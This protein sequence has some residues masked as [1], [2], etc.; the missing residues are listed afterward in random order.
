MPFCPNPECPHRKRFG[1]PAEY[2]KETSTCS[3]CGSQLSETPPIF[4]SMQ[5]TMRSFL[6]TKTDKLIIV[7]LVLFIISLAV[8]STAR[9]LGMLSPASA[10]FSQF[11]LQT[12]LLGFLYFFFGMSVQLG[13]AVWLFSEVKKRGGRFLLWSFL[14]LFTGV[15]AVILWYLI[16][17]DAQLAQTDKGE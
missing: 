6:N 11:S 5:K 17:I 3:D 15:M 14:G 9:I 12:R 2:R 13:C 7:L 10:G 8:T 4:E 1:E 16:K